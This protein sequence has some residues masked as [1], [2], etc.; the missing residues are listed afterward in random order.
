M[1][2]LHIITTSKYQKRPGC[3]NVILGHDN[4]GPENQG[5]LIAVV[6]PTLVENTKLLE[7]PI[8]I[9]MTGTSSLLEL[10]Y[11]GRIAL[12]NHRESIW[13]PC[14]TRITN[15]HT[16]WW[17]HAHQ[18]LAVN[19]DVVH[20]G[21]I[22][23]TGPADSIFT[24]ANSQLIVKSRGIK[25]VRVPL[26]GRVISRLFDFEVRAVNSKNKNCVII[27]WSEKDLAK[28]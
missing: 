27:P 19:G 18:M 5:M 3:L 28:S 1:T 23:S 11:F 25:L 26:A 8:D 13:F 15:A 20:G 21:W 7:A 22:W 16:T 9:F 4:Q 12:A 6:C 24:N 2:P 17:H 10:L 14:I